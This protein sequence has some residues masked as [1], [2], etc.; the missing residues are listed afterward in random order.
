MYMNHQPN[1]NTWKC[2]NSQ[3]RVLGNFFSSFCFF[4]AEGGKN[5]PT[6]CKISN[7]ED[8]IGLLGT[9]ASRLCGAPPI[10]EERWE[11]R[12]CSCWGR[13]IL[14]LRCFQ[15][16]TP[17]WS[18]KNNYSPIKDK[19]ITWE[20]TQKA[21]WAEQG[22]GIT[23][24]KRSASHPIR[25]R[26]AV[27]GIHKECKVI[28]ICAESCNILQQRHVYS[29]YLRTHSILFSFWTWKLNISQSFLLQLQCGEIV[30]DLKIWNLCFKISRVISIY[31]LS[32][33]YTELKMPFEMENA[34]NLR[35]ISRSPSLF[36]VLKVHLLWA[37]HSLVLL[38]SNNRMKFNGSR[39]SMWKF[40]E[41]LGA[42]LWRVRSLY[43]L[44][45]HDLNKNIADKQH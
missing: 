6:Y 23:S 26:G 31:L 15:S 19:D 12:R 36:F 8:M 43:L 29:F 32:W 20:G 42:E 14:S 40:K 41:N 45:V 33:K 3:R 5:I 17:M 13:C 18:S 10:L 11:Q 37:C 4:F 35:N 2:H 9:R 16:L 21:F 25:K 30:H 28:N 38:F 7:T 39:H 22:E 1:V 34:L 24:V 44:F 27:G